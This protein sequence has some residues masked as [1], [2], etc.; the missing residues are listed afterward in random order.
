MCAW[1]RGHVLIGKIPN[2]IGMDTYWVG[3]IYWVK[4]LIK[5]NTVSQKH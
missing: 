4:T 3:R 5:K 2:E 1:G